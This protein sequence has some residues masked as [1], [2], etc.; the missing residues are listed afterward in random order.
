M[1]I[2]PPSNIIRST[3]GSR[4]KNYSAPKELMTASSDVYCR[5]QQWKNFESR[6]TIVEVMGKS[7]VSC[8]LTDGYVHLQQ[9][10]GLT[11]K[12]WENSAKSRG[13]ACMHFIQTVLYLRNCDAQ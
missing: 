7:R 12:K 11:A 8:F 4:P 5:V 1:D 10:G 2:F 6:L 13:L 9:N 3:F